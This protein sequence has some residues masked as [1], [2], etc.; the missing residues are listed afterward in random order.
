MPSKIPIKFI[1][2]YIGS[3]V[4]FMT[5]I[6]LLM[7]LGNVKIP[8]ENKD[9]FVAITGSLSASLAMVISVLIGKSPEEVEE[10][11]KKNESLKM[12]VE[13]L[14]KQK[15]SLEALVISTQKDLV[16]NVKE[17]KLCSILNMKN[18]IH[19]IYLEVVVSLCVLIFWSCSTLQGVKLELNSESLRAIEAEN[20]M[21]KLEANLNRLIWW[22]KQQILFARTRVTD[23]LLSRPSLWR[24]SRESVLPKPL[25]TLIPI[26]KQR[27]VI[28]VEK[29][30]GHTNT[31]GSTIWLRKNLKIQK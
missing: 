26:P 4:L 31:S 21:R 11:K 19:L 22:E 6:F 8:P 2:H 9:I 10:L 12:T 14:V 30:S 18:L 3:A 28:K 17:S 7:Y 5:V 15:D 20:T 29:S 27:G 23:S 25:F 1:Y 13:Q 24:V 16:D